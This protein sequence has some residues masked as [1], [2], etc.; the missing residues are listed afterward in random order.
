MSAAI[1]ERGALL[2]A[3]GLLLGAQFFFNCVDTTG[4]YLV[5]DY[6]VI[7]VTWSRYV[8]HTLFMLAYAFWRFGGPPPLPKRKGI[9]VWRGFL[10]LGFA[11]FLFATLKYL[12]Q[13]E[14]VA[15]SFMS[16]LLILL[17]AGPTLG[18]R[19]TLAR[20][21]AALAGFTGMLVVVRPANE[22]ATIGVV[23]GI[24][25]LVCNTGFQLITRYLANADHPIVTILWT[26]AVGTLAS[27]V[28]LPFAPPDHWPT[29]WQAVLFLSMGITGS[30]CHLLLIEA[31]R[32][33][34]ASYLA[35]F[36]YVHI[37]YA[38]AFGWAV[39]GQFPDAITLAGIA[40]I[41]A[42]GAGIALYERSRAARRAA[43]AT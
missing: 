37:A 12:P 43:P 25:T 4:K 8:F 5:Q 21:I 35:P 2:K 6:S 30:I 17:L 10:L 26:A 22:L 27:T 38:T 42:S 18:E 13:A 33:V 1:T 34:P 40:L 7:T 24:L 41:G 29:A 14:A 31:Y 15:I 9:I 20:W 11:A 19:V 23:F 3:V 32:L 36:I 16:P 28:L 39:F